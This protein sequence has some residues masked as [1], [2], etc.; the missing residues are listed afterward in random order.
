[1]PR[2]IPLFWTATLI[3]NIALTFALV[4]RFGARGAATA[5]TLSYAM[6]FGLVLFYFHDQTGQSLAFTLTPRRVELRELFAGRFRKLS[7][8]GSRG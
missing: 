6:I 8:G 3:I 2:A 4:P 7:G 5:S 1:L